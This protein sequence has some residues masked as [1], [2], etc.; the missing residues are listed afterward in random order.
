M[1]DE[2]GKVVGRIE[3]MGLAK[4]ASGFGKEEDY[5][6]GRRFLISLTGSHDRQRKVSE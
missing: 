5:K 3:L 4:L 2:P 1:N 6:E